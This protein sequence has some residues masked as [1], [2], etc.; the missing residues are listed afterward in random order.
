MCLPAQIYMSQLGRRGT[1]LTSNKVG[2]ARVKVLEH[3]L[4]GIWEKQGV[5]IHVEQ[6]LEGVPKVLVGEEGHQCSAGVAR[7]FRPGGGIEGRRSVQATRA[8]L[9]ISLGHCRKREGRLAHS[10]RASY[11]PQ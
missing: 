5:I 10:N 6:P 8:G 11:P 7:I 9:C 1:M 2:H 3:P 4:D